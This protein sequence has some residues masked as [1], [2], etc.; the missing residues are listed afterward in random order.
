MWPAKQFIEVR[1]AGAHPVELYPSLRAALFCNYEFDRVLSEVSEGRL[2]TIAELLRIGS[3]TDLQDILDGV[4]LSKVLPSLIDG[5]GEY[6]LALADTGN[7][8]KGGKQ[9]GKPLTFAE[10]HKQL[11]QIAT[12]WLGWSPGQAWDATP[13]EILT[14]YEGHIEKLKAI[15]GSSA[16]EEWTPESAE[17]AKLDRAGLRRLKGMVSSYAG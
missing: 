1:L 11:F 13:F 16:E 6:I 8:G 7:P 2:S 5:C 17:E 12:G 4:P 14:A 3:R 10:F 9:G 15:H